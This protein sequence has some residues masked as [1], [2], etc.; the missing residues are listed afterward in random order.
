[1]TSAVLTK[2]RGFEFGAES[3]ALWSAMAVMLLTTVHHS[4]G[5]IIYNTP[6]RHHVA[7][8]GVGTVLVLFA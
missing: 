3:R 1:M 7:I 5:A 2:T 4:Y 6:W 8:V